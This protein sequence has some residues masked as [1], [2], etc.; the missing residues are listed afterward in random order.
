[1]VCKTIITCTNFMHITNAGK[2]LD[3]VRHKSGKQSEKRQYTIIII[4]IKSYKCK[5]I[6]FI[7][8]R[9][10]SIQSGVKQDSG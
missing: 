2:Y 4:I 3:K 7:W 10:C 1:M 6:E 8:D 5:I 9:Q